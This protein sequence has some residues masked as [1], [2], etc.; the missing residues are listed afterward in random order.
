[1]ARLVF[2]HV[3]DDLAAACI[4]GWKHVEMAEEMA[5]DL[6]F[7]FGEESHAPPIPCEPRQHAQSEGS[8]VPE[9]IEEARP[10]VEL[11]QPIA[12]P[13]EVVPLFGGGRVQRTAH[14][15]IAR[16]HL[17]LAVE[18]LRADLAGVVNA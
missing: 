5:L 9:R 4:P 6:V 7:G 17:L 14:V 11:A 15:R 13:R 1:M 10:R 8:G 12:A 2:P 18:S 16:D 3:R